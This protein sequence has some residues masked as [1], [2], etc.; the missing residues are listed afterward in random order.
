MDP[1][2]RATVAIQGQFLR[3]SG[4]R[5]VAIYLRDGRLWVADFIDGRGAIVDAVTWFR[6][7][8]GT[9]CQA[10]RRMVLEGAIALSS[11]IVERIE[12]LHELLEAAD[13]GEAS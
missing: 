8:C 7:N 13:P 10:R 5:E 3:L 1:E 4:R 2:N 11:P 6:F 12:Q 9:A